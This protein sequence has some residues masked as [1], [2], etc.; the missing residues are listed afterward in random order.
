MKSKKSVFTVLKNNR[1]KLS[2]LA[3]LM[4]CIGVYTA[5]GGAFPGDRKVNEDVPLHDG[6]V[7]VD[8]LNISESESADSGSSDSDRKKDESSLVTS[9]DVSELKNTDT[10]FQ[11]LRATL[12]MDRNKIISMLTESESSASSR[13]E[14]EKSTSEKIKLLGYMEQEKTLETLVRNKG[15]PET[16][17]VISDTGVNV[18]VNTKKLDQQMV[19]RICEIIMRNTGREADEIV[20]QDAP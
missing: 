12:D 6:D 9:D 18:T 3:A 14:K 8:S 5:A 10:Y 4:I 7:L 15:L 19:T 17:I 1:K 2:V 11:E 13:T 16:F 20:V